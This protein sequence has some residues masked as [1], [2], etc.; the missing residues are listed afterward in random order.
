[1]QIVGNFTGVLP[2]FTEFKL[3]MFVMRYLISSEERYYPLLTD[4]SEIICP[5]ETHV[6]GLEKGSLLDCKIGRYEKIRIFL[7]K[8]DVPPG[9]HCHGSQ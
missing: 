5:A 7:A 3:R 9:A 2:L 8:R 1:M 6:G 4:V